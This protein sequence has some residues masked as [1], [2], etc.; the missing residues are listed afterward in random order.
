MDIKFTRSARSIYMIKRKTIKINMN[1][2]S[3]SISKWDPQRKK[4]GPKTR[5]SCGFPLTDQNL[6]ISSNNDPEGFLETIIA[7]LSTKTVEDQDFKFKRLAFEK[8]L[9]IQ[10][11]KCFLH[12]EIELSR[13]FDW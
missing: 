5:I 13:V 2:Y 12:Y 3:T 10:Y 6:A 7:H 1:A 9:F 8:N 4:Y 11:T